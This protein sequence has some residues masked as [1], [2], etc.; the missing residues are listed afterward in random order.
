MS[1]KIYREVTSKFN[2]KTQKWE[3]ISEDSYDY[4]GPVDFAQGDFDEEDF[5]DLKDI[6]KDLGKTFEKSMKKAINT[7]AS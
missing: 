4:E 6:F 5:R 2:D 1:T 3:T 7:G